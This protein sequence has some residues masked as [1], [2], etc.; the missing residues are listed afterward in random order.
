[1]C[2]S[3]WDSDMLARRWTW[4]LHPH[5]SARITI[6]RERIIRRAEPSA[7]SVYRWPTTYRVT[8]RRARRRVGVALL[9][10][11]ASRWQ[12]PRSSSDARPSSPIRLQPAEALGEAVRR[13]G[14]VE[15]TE[16]AVLAQA[17]VP[18]ETAASREVA[19]AEAVSAEVGSGEVVP[20]EAV[21]AEVAPAEAA[22]PRP[23][24]S[25]PLP[26]RS[27]V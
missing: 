18:A 13:V 16:A 17:V 26:R 22:E 11:R 4:E 19:P 1:M 3:H 14:T 12:A 7:P 27:A 15:L 5:Y 2:A 6:C 23:R 9:C 24:F 20:A 8:T 25:C 10:A 21:P